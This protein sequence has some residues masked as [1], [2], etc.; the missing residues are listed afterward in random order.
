MTKRTLYEAIIFSLLI[1]AEVL[2]ILI[3][4]FNKSTFFIAYD[5]IIYMA[6][7]FVNINV[8]YGVVVLI[9]NTS[10]GKDNIKDDKDDKDQ[11]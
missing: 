2:L 9:I 3:F 10:G 1:A 5:T 4:L 7:L 6:M 8:I 11:K